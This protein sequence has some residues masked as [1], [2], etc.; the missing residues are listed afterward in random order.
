[1]VSG[2]IDAQA[3]VQVL[4]PDEIKLRQ[5]LGTGLTDESKTGIGAFNV[6]LS[7]DD[8]KSAAAKP[9]APVEPMTIG[10]SICA[11]HLCN[12]VSRN[13]SSATTTRRSSD[14]G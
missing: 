11:Y 9:S 14:T 5:P 12:D 6:L 10:A 7:R 4:V 13:G 1:M 8:V 3:S 2:Y